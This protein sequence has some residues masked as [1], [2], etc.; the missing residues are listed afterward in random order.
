MSKKGN[1]EG[2]IYFV[3]SRKRWCGQY[4]I[5][6][7]DDGKLIRKTVYG[8][9]R[10]EV[11][12]KINE[13]LTEIKNNEYIDK[14][15]ITLDKCMHDKVD[16]QYNLEQVK[17]TTYKRNL[18]TI[19]IIEKCMPKIAYSNIQDITIADINNNLRNIT[20]YSQNVIDKCTMMMN[21]TFNYAVINK[22]VKENPFAIKGAVIR[23][24]KD[25][26][27]KVVALTIEE[28][29][30]FVNGL[31]KYYEPYR[32]ILFIALYS[33][34]RI[35]EILALTYDDIDLENKVIHVSKTLTRDENDKTIVGKTTK[36]YSGQRDVPIIS[37]LY[38]ILN[39]YENEHT[40]TLFTKDNKLITPSTINAHLKRI[41]T[42]ANIRPVKVN[43]TKRNKKGEIIKIRSSEVHTHMLRHTFATRCIESGMQAVTLSRIL[44]HKDISVTLN[45]YTDVFNQ[46]KEKEVNKLDEYL[47]GLQSRCIQE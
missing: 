44:G 27:K 5:G 20:K 10:K 41:C 26:N 8:K 33:G 28:Q 2:T 14:N 38:D 13:Y 17:S 36:T 43:S 23:P 3:P 47:N 34:I 15:D 6:R 25:D 45:T 18:Y 4:V 19:R 1:G 40:G 12:E 11:S 24:K 29:Q 46:F 42:K 39:S 7:D 22:L 32:T 31:Q 37:T 35:G 30:A 9:T 21:S 16:L